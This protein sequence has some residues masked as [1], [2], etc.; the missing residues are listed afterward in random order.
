M[1]A[2]LR[3]V[4]QFSRETSATVIDEIKP[5]LDAHYAEI[6]HYQDI[7]VNVAYEKYLA[8]EA[9]G[10]LRIYTVRSRGELVGYAIFT[11]APSL[12]YSGSL[13]AMQDV[14]YLHPWYRKGRVGM[15]F[16]EWCDSQLRVDGAQVVY[17]HQKIA[18]PA[19]GKLLARIGYE[20]IDTIWARRLDRGN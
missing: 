13:Q 16:I 6:A 3:P 5:L 10:R 1:N 7:P 19:L 20:A 2:Q 12:H 15:R 14:L 8:V 9:L 17:Q 4:P 18:H 11:L